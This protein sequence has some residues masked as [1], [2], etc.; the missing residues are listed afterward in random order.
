MKIPGI[1]TGKKFFR[2][3]RAR[4]Y[5]GALILGYHRISSPEGGPDDVSVS[6]EN[7]AEHMQALREYANPISLSKLVQSLK[8]NALPSKSVAVTFDDGYADN[9]YVAKPILEKHGIPA[10]V[11]ICTG[12]A[13]REF[14]WDELERLV[15]CSR[16]DPRALRVQLGSAKIKW[17]YPRVNPGMNNQSIQRQFYRML[18]QFLLSLDVDDQNHVMGLIRSW[19]EVPS[20]RIADARAMSDEE[21]LRLLDGGLIEPGAH[22]RHHPML[23]QLSVERQREEILSSK[24]DLE[25]LLGQNINGFSYPNGRAT[26]DTKQLVRE[27]EFSYACTSIHDVVGLRSDLYELTRFWQQNVD[28]ERFMKKLNRWMSFKKS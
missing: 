27:M 16:A 13:G 2:L 23:P 18:Y 7:F 3:L 10:T 22:T 8:Q 25:T 1:K 21:L 4:I 12:Y 11:F 24:Q 5:G 6:S 15:F 9:L 20:P 14:W 26:V 17:D 19:S 28:G